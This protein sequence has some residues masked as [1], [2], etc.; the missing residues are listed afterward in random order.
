[1]SSMP[2]VFGR[3]CSGGVVGMERQRNKRLE[4]AGLVLQRA[5]LEQVIDAVFVVFDV[6]VEHGRVGVQSDLVGES[7]SV[8]PLVAVDLV[9]ADDVAHAVGENLGA[10]AGQRIHA[11]GFQLFQRLADRELRAASTDTR[12]PPS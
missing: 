9:V 4:A 10:A 12:L 3:C 8:E 7:R 6:A 2:V 5:Q 1:M 11:C